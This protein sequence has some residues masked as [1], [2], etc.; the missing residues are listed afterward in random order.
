[1]DVDQGTRFG[2]WTDPTSRLIYHDV[3]PVMLTGIDPRLQVLDLGGGNRLLQQWL[4]YSIAVDVDPSKEP[5]VVADVLTYTPRVAPDLVVMRYLLHYL[6]DA[7]VVEL[8][9]HVDTY[10]DGPV[11]VIQFVN[12][13]FDL[14]LKRRNSINEVKHFRNEGH[15]LSLVGLG[16]PRFL[17][18][19]VAVEYEVT[20]EFYRNR[21]GNPDGVTHNETVVSYLLTKDQ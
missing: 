18:R 11:L 15:L 7:Q 19:R 20:A 13:G 3:M 17:R 8:L 12:D 2:S 9:R 6:T 5:D 1:M 10:H 16:G 4:P 14:E 21:L